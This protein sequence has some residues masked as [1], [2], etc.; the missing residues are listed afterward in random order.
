VSG[1]SRTAESR[2]LAARLFSE[3]FLEYRQHFRRRAGQEPAETFEEPFTVHR[4]ELI[5][6]NE[7]GPILKAAADSPR[8]RMP[9]GSHRR[10]DDRS[11]MLVQFV[12]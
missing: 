8:V 1:F 10:N 11:Q 6:N 4:S 12:G 5:E 9:T 7:P 3:H 2:Q